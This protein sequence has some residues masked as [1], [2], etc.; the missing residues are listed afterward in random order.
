MINTKQTKQRMKH[1]R[2]GVFFHKMKFG[3]QNVTRFVQVYRVWI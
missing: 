3:E 1:H 2:C